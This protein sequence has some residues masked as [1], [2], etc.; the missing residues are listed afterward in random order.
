MSSLTKSENNSY[1]DLRGDGQVVI[2]KRDETSN[3]Y[4]RLKVLEG[5]GSYKFRVRSLKT[6]DR[7]QAVSAAF[8]THDEITFH[9]KSGGNLDGRTFRKVFEE[10]KQTKLNTYDSK[11][12]ADRTVEY[13]GLYSLDYFGSMIFDRISTQDFYQYWDWR[14]VNYKRRKPSDETLNRERS[15]IMSIFKFGYQRGYIKELIKIPKLKTNGVN[16]RPTFTLAEWKKITKGMRSWVSEGIDTGHWRERFLLQQYVLLMSNSGVRV[17]EM[18]NLRWEDVSS[19]K[20]DKGK[21]FILRVSGKTGE[22]DVVLNP[23]SDTY[24]KRLYD[25]RTS[26]LGHSP[27]PTEYVFISG[28]T[29]GPYTSFKTSFNNMLKFCEVPIEKGGMNRTIYSLRHFYGTQR[30][31]GNINP[32]VLSKQMGTSVEMIEKFYGHIMTKDVM[33][34]IKQ[35][36]NQRSLDDGDQISYPFD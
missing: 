10:W 32:Y 20:S 4:V 1:E 16:R 29:G 3:Y 24:L 14:K 22:R 23:Y 2:Y 13:A 18:R 21:H 35:S 9:L 27:D 5:D 34:T 33:D 6:K 7:S 36:T 25:L 28:K 26:E 19:V 11:A 31:K 30:L 15:A 17:G 8:K 12:K